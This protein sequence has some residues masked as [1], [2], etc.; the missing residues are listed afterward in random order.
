MFPLYG[1]TEKSHFQ[2]M[3]GPPY[4]TMITYSDTEFDSPYPTY[5]QYTFTL[6]S[7]IGDFRKYSQA[8]FDLLL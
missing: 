1:T 2:D 6:G 4:G 5:I 7:N 3:W 8:S